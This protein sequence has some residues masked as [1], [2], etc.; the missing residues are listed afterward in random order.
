MNHCV[1]IITANDVTLF[2]MD[3]HAD[4]DTAN[5]PL[6]GLG[7]KVARRREEL[8][9]SQPELIERMNRTPF[10]PDIARQS[11]IS[12]IEN[13]AGDKL[14]SIRVL[15]A[16][17]L[18]LETNMD[19]LA[20]LTDDDKPASDLED[21]LVIDV[22]DEEERALL[23]ELFTLIHKRRREEQHFVADVVRRLVSAPPPPSTKSPI[24]IGG[25]SRRSR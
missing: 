20:G 10:R 25:E 8:R 12:N 16:L 19:F 5:D 23:L 13:S 4:N 18:A 6:T 24:V 15:A 22:R 9:L 21:Q 2:F 11:H 17:A 14:P 3:A 7:R 1:E